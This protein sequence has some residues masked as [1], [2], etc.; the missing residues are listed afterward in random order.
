MFGQAVSKHDCFGLCNVLV[1]YDP[2]VIMMLFVLKGS[3]YSVGCL[4][5]ETIKIVKNV[6][7]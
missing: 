3:K 6:K 4:Q 1:A 7:F 5:L 2:Q